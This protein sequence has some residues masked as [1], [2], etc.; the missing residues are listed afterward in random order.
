MLK[1]PSQKSTH[2]ILGVGALWMMQVNWESSPATKE[3]FLSLFT[4]RGGTESST[5]FTIQPNWPVEP[6][7]TPTV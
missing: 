6:L 5:R 3:E 2:L 7:W 1:V 4:K